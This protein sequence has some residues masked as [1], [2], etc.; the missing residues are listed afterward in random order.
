MVDPKFRNINRLLYLSLQNG[1][2]N[3]TI[4][5]LVSY[6]MPQVEIKDVNALVE[7]RAFLINK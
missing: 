4:N 3:P 7:N 5:C 2:N 1:H 6:Y